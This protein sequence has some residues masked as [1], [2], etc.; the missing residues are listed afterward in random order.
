M[1]LFTKLTTLVFFFL[2]FT[3][4]AQD[5]YTLTVKASAPAVV[6]GRSDRCEVDMRDC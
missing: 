2:S 4:Q 5:S 3:T 1:R 6:L